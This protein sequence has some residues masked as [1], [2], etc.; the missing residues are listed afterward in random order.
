MLQSSKVVLKLSNGPEQAEVMIVPRHK[1]F[2][3]AG[4]KATTKTKVCSDTSTLA[5]TACCMMY[6]MY[7]TIAADNCSLA[8]GRS[9][10]M[11]KLPTISVTSSMKVSWKRSMKYWPTWPLDSSCQDG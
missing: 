4:K 10:Q 6:I 9:C 11:A 5:G 2:E 3:G 1:K 8:P 7:D